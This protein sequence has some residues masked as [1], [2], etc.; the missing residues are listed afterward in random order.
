MASPSPVTKPDSTSRAVPPAVVGDPVVAELVT[1]VDGDPQGPEI[2]LPGHADR[3]AEPAGEGAV[4]AGGQVELPQLG[5]SALLVE[6]CSATL[7]FDPIA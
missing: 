4:G 2:R 3:V 5:A 1:L 6:P 7:L